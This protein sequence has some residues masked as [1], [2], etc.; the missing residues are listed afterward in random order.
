MVR[1]RTDLV[2][3]HPFFGYLALQLT[4]VEDQSCDTAWTDGYVLAYNPLYVNM[5]PREPSYA[6]LWVH[7]GAEERVP[8]LGEYSRMI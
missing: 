5:L 7:P 8:P 2:L 3:A 6:V 4:L 1:A